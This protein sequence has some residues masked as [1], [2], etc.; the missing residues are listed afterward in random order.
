MLPAATAPNAII[1][2]ASGISTFAMM[3]IGFVM[4]VVCVFATVAAVELYGGAMF[5]FGEELP[6]WLTENDDA[7]ASCSRNV[8]SGIISA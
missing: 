4:N 6:A 5:D 8:S 2:E 3:R 7:Y 1:K